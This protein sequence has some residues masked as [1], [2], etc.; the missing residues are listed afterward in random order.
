MQALRSFQHIALQKDMFSLYRATTNKKCQKI[1]EE[2]INKVN[3]RT[4]KIRRV[5]DKRKPIIMQFETH[6]DL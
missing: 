1:K 4:D 2:L 6:S 3:S 5:S